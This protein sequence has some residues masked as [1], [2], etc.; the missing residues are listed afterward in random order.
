[1]SADELRSAL[2]ALET[3]RD[4]AEGEP[5]QRLDRIVDKVSAALDAGRQLDHGALARMDRTL[6]E[7]T[8]ETD[9]ETADA[10]ADSKAALITYRE[11][12]PGA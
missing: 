12:V 7:L 4:L 2:E 8:D 1:M 6:D 5:E 11:G 10:V 3:A 9:G